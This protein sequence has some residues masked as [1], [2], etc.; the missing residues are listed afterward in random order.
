MKI[1]TAYLS[2]DDS[3]EKYAIN[4]LSIV[5]KLTLITMKIYHGDKTRAAIY[6]KRDALATFDSMVRRVQEKMSPLDKKEP[7]KW[8][9]PRKE[10]PVVRRMVRTNG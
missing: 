8:K 10:R 3:I 5:K 4:F 6:S 1:I 2:R 9:K 7:M